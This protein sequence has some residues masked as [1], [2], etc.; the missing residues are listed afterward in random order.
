M[1]ANELMQNLKNELV[2]TRAALVASQNR[3]FEL[4][5][6][7]RQIRAAIKMER[8]EFGKVVHAHEHRRNVL[9]H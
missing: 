2:E 5:V 3:T 4:K 8:D 7:V 6:Y 9:T 1:N